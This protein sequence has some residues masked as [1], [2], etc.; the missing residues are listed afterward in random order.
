MPRAPK[1]QSNKIKKDDLPDE[2]N[3]DLSSNKVMHVKQSKEK[4]KKDNSDSSSILATDKQCNQSKDKKDNSD[5][6]SIIAT[7]KQCNQSKDKKDID[8]SDISDID[9]NQCVSDAFNYDSKNSSNTKDD[10]NDDLN[11]ESRKKY[12]QTVVLDRVIKY[13]KIDDIIKKKHEEFKKEMKVIKDSKDKLEQFLIEYLDKINEEYIQVGNKSTLI[14]TEVKSKAAPKMEDISVCL[15]EGF[16]KHELC[17]NDD[18]E[19]KKVI[20]E[21]ITTIDAKREIKTRKYLKRMNGNP[22]DEKKGRRKKSTK[23]NVQKDDVQKDDNKSTNC[24]NEPKEL[25]ND[26]II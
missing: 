8:S 24:S 11:D 21:F 7:D 10:A 6:S 13:I 3:N 14:K 5:S 4:I 15:I 20:K 23:D 1:K 2:D 17:N 9:D 12:I 16:K 18:E 25:I 19:I 22:N 26:K